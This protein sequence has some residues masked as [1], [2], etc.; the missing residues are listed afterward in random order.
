[1]KI[2]VFKRENLAFLLWTTLKHSETLKS[3]LIWL[4][5]L[6]YE[7]ILLININVI[8]NF[9]KYSLFSFKMYSVS[10]LLFKELQDL[11]FESEK[12]RIYGIWWNMFGWKRRETWSEI[13][14]CKSSYNIKAQLFF[15]VINFSSL[16][17]FN[18]WINKWRRRLIIIW[19]FCWKVSHFISTFQQN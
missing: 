6:L 18:P 11:H 10:L 15:V 2:S 16:K 13:N 7:S 5:F 8:T 12:E 4:N 1:M 19:K 17:L 3:S 14:L 9:M